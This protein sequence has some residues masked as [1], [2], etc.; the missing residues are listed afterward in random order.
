MLVHL[1]IHHYATI[2]HLDLELER[3]MS[4]ITGETGAGK[5]I[6]LDALGLALGDRA[7]SSAVRPGYPKAEILAHFDLSQRPEAIQ[8][9]KERD[10]EQEDQCWLRRI[11]TQE[12]RSRAYINGTLCPQSDLKA[13]GGL[14][15]DIHSQ[16]EHQS[17]LH[18]DTHRRLLDEYSNAQELAQNVQQRANHWQQTRRQSHD[19]QQQTQHQQARHQLQNYQLPE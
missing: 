4:V 16:H 9:L 17:L 3:G 7:D 1:T 6:M 15:I 2:E 11:I 19:H 18:T 8:W 12:G 13:L 5:S 14:L 10:L